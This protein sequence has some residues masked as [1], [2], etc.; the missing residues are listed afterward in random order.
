VKKKFAIFIGSEQK[1]LYCAI[2]NIL[3]KKYNFSVVIIARDSQVKRYVD[4]QLPGRK[5]DIVLT[6]LKVKINHEKFI[7][8]ALEIEDKYEINL[9]ILT[10]EDRSLGQGYLLNVENIPDIIRSSWSHKEKILDIVTRIKKYELALKGIDYSI[11][12][13]PDKCIT[14]IVEKNHGR[15]FSLTAIKYKDRYLWSDNNFVT[16]DRYIRHINRN[17]ALFSN[18]S[19]SFESKYEIDGDGNKANNEI[20]YTVM[21]AIRKGL[22]IFFNDT[23]NYI[24]RINKKNSYHYLG[25]IP[26]VFRSITNYRYVKSISIKPK[27]I[28]NNYRVCYFSLHLEPEVALLSFSPEFS[29]SLEAISWISK[30]LPA[31]TLLV[32]KEQAR[33]FGVRSRWY[34]KQLNKIGNVALANPEVNSWN[35]LKKVD[36]VATITGTVGVE[37]VYHHKPVISF[38]KHQV[39]NFLPT[40]RFVSNY[41]ETKNAI[42]DLLKNDIPYEIFEQSRLSL[43]R[44][45][46]DNSFNLSKYKFGYK[47]SNPEADTE[48]AEIAVENLLSMNPDLKV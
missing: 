40:V 11:K 6:Q 45:Q 28:D 15:S 31:D 21:F 1:G 12:I 17:L 29:N 41:V 23:K 38:G 20:E 14:A 3:E 22:K 26:S 9:S 4:K 36:L 42:Y 13:W 47:N 46:L 44:S 35:W 37:A 32:V 24:R 18:C 30:S 33:S 19:N 27:D 5:N 25:W 39:I 48:M 16:S 2:A 43:E 7:L 34:Y 10:S 8:E